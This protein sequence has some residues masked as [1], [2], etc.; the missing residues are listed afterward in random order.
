[1][2]SKEIFESSRKS[3][4]P[5]ISDVFYGTNETANLPAPEVAPLTP[6]SSAK[7]ANKTL[8]RRKTFRDGYEEMVQEFRFRHEGHV[9][10]V[11]AQPTILSKEDFLATVGLQAKEGSSS[12]IDSD[13]NSY[14]QAVSESD[15]QEG[16]FVVLCHLR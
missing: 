14:V 8:M 6:E 12:N 7:Y 1:M 9:K 3:N 5:F 15:S 2:I 10:D 16:R 11:I 13:S 4:I